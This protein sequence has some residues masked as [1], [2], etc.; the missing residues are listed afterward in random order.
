[1]EALYSE[2]WDVYCWLDETSWRI[3]SLR[4][5]NLAFVAGN[6]VYN[7]HGR[8]IGW[9]QH[10]HMRDKKGAVAL[11]TAGATMLGVVTP[12]RAVRPVQPVEQVP[13]VRPAKQVKPAKPDDQMAW[14]K[15]LPF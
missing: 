9:W 7:W 8:H 1:M 4:G 10:G 13:P 6:S 3:I 14:S 5:N 15:Q 11:F 2:S 12:V